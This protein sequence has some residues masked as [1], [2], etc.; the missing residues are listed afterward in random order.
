MTAPLKGPKPRVRMLTPIWGRDY[1]ERWLDLCFA[2]MLSDGNIPY[3]NEH[4]DFE[5]AILTTAADI[6]LLRENARFKIL[7]AGIRIRF[8]EL[9]EF[10]PRTGKTAYGIPLTLAYAKG[11]LDLGE[12]GIGSYVM[13]MNADVV[14]ASG[15]LK[16]VVAR[17]QEGYDIVA[18]T[19]IRAI[20]GT[21]RAMLYRHVEPKTG[22]ITIDPRAMMRLANAHL[23]STVAA[24]IINDR[25]PIDSTYYHQI[26]WRVSN[27]C[28]ALRGFL[29]QP[30]CFRVK[31]LMTKVLCPVDYGFLTELCPDARFC[32]L[33]DSDEYFMLELQ[34]RDSESHWLRVASQDGV[35][36]RRFDRLA[37]EISAQAG[38]WATAEHRRSAG[39]T[40]LYH[41]G[42]LP[43][44]AAARLA[45]FD[46]FVDGMLARMPPP[47]SHIRHFQW[48]P[49]V[50]IYREEMRRSGSDANIAL[51]DDPRNEPSPEA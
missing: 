6:A 43:A 17:L 16:S 23:H 37:R 28:L 20:D 9:D 12:P 24:R 3:M 40:I 30:L 5:L 15:S 29:L 21:A 10:L 8:V 44:D 50:R 35:F 49:A 45:P 48:L 7:T 19:S 51:L 2:S 1:I 31:R 47:V 41:A 46:Q 25:S 14:L 33:G 26:F 36:T 4:C 22:V 11:I 42:D 13:L 34:E 38:R 27:D 18:A 39:A 32:V